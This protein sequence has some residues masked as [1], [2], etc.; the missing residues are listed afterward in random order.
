MAMRQ[1]PSETEFNSLKNDLE[2]KVRGFLII[3]KTTLT[4]NAETTLRKLQLEIDQRNLELKK[5]EQAEE[6]VSTVRLFV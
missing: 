5:L 3:F 6:R 2:K 4:D 1:L